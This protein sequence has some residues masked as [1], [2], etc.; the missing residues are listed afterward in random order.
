MNYNPGRWRRTQFPV[1]LDEESQLALQR[2][3][4][5][6]WSQSDVIRHALIDAAR[7]ARR[8][9]LRAD[10]ERRAADASDRAVIADVQEFM[11]RLAPW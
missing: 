6:G 10:A 3:M 8:E 9:Q 11:D 7:V 5:R 4:E 2:L 1:R